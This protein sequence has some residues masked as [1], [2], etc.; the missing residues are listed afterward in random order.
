MKRMMI[1]A[2]LGLG[3]A[4]AAHASDPVEGVWMTEVDDGAYAHVTIDAC[5]PAYCGSITK[6]FKADGSEYNSEN[7]GTMIVID[8]LPQG[9]GNYEGQ[10]FRPSNGKTYYGT[11][12]LSGDQLKLAG[13][14]AGGLICGRQDWT[15]VD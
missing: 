8:M 6:T 1:A 11:I 13:C 2:V 4:G 10:V 7:I 9:D 15:R 5:G 12:I 14:V 3:L